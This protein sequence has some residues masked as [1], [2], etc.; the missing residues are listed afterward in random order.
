MS[1]RRPSIACRLDSL[2]AISAQSPPALRGLFDARF[3]AGA[4]RGLER[5]GAAAAPGR[6][7]RVRA[8]R[9]CAGRARS[10]PDVSP[11]GHRNG[12]DQ[13]GRAGGALRPLDRHDR[14]AVQAGVPFGHGLSRDDVLPPD[15]RRSRRRRSAID[16][17]RHQPLL[18]G[19]G[20]IRRARTR[21]G[22]LRRHGRRRARP[23]GRR[24][25]RRA[26][27]RLDADHPKGPPRARGEATRFGSR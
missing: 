15:A 22:P 19:R 20:N 26:D 18:C 13:R 21:D 12:R 8:R 16:P 3:P 6:A 23:S 7:A 2:G 10:R 5:I 25:V 27:E 11:R 9:S 4:R 1:H 17:R 14:L 24:G